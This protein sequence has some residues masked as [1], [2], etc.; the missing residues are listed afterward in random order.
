MQD[1]FTLGELDE[2]R[3]FFRGSNAKIVSEFLSRTNAFY[4]T[5]KTYYER[6]EFKNC[7]L[8]GE[9]YLMLDNSER[10]FN[11]ANVLKMMICILADVQQRYDDAI[12]YGADLLSITENES[13][14]IDKDK[15]TGGIYSA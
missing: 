6:N 1:T 7:I 8:L 13:T 10:E 11:K 2:Y 5:I 12:I 15:I 9:K 14:L 3:F 4:D